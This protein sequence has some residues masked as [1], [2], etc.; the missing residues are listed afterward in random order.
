MIAAQYIAS[1]LSDSGL[2]TVFGHLG[3]FN[4]DIVDA[5]YADPGL[6][7]VLNYHEQ[8]ASFAADAYAMVRDDLGVALSSGAP[9]SCNLIPGIANA[10]FD[11]VACLFIAGSVH[12]KA[13]RE[14]DRI[15]QNAFEEIDLVG[16]VS[17]LT[18]FAA[19]VTDPKN[20]RFY[21]EKAV[22]TAREG[23]RGP[24]LLDIPYDVA[25]AKVE[26]EKLR[27]FVPPPPEP[28]DRID[29]EAMVRTLGR[30]NKPLLLLGGGA[31]NGRGRELVKKLLDQA[32][33]P[34]VA[35]L[36]GLDVLPHDHPCFVGYIGHYGNRYA[37]FALANCD[38]LIV[39]GSRL[40]ERQ[41]A[42]DPSR[43]APRAEVIRVDLDRAELGRKIPEKFSIYSSVEHFL[44]QLVSANL[45]DLNYDRWRQVI[46]R[47][48]DRYPSHDFSLEEVNA[49][50][51][52]QTLSCLL[53]DDAIICADV[54]QNQMFVAQSLRLDQNR[55]LLNSSGYGSMGYSLPA[56]VGVAMARP[57][58]VVVSINGDGG[59]QMNIQELQT[60]A[61]D[62]LPVKIVVLNNNCLGMI[63]RLQERIFDDRTVASI[64][65]YCA[66]NY[67]ALAAA[68]G[69]EYLKI[70]SAC[71]YE[72]VEKF[73]SGP[74][75]ALLEVF[76]PQK[77]MNNPEPG[78]ALDLQT[79]LL[80]EYEND[81]IKK[82][83]AF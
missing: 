37:N 62:H 39:L 74:A 70:D 45:V 77:I 31:R 22:Y 49:N 75:P 4:A 59:L 5:V 29:L 82:E 14:S 54:G 65:G 72:S 3:G 53:A 15:R 78:A 48:K 43:F 24:V 8:A 6:R 11:S 55:R 63:R 7:F 35:S 71:R 2:D 30:A 67:S 36:C 18:K 68:Y 81:R 12:S 34:A 47:W 79:P 17:G 19:K 38:C 52:L 9:S 25:R 73:L 13:V 83:S 28:F 51:F 60:I 64:E 42:G 57:G 66:P 69:L 40:D 76:L 56:A 61:R 44:D 80:P 16:L 46:A 1:F 23:R 41:I 10:Y 20:L 33:I 32:A 50:N 26:P 27:G 58:T 21:L